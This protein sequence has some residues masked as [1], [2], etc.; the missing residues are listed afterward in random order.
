MVSNTN[1][2][3][4]TRFFC[5]IFN[6]TMAEIW[7]LLRKSGVE[8]G[9]VGQEICPKTKSIHFHVFGRY[10]KKRRLTAIGKHFG[11]HI[12]YIK[13]HP[14]TQEYMY[15]EAQE[16]C[17]KDGLFQE[18][19]IPE[20]E[21]S[22]E[23]KPCPFVTCINLAMAGKFDEIR[24]DFPKMY[25]IHLTKW[26]AIFAE[27][28]SKIQFPNRKCLWIHG[29]SGIGKSRWVQTNFPSAYRKNAGEVHFERY[30]GEKV[31]VIEDFLPDHR[32]E[33]SHQMLMISDI[34]SFMPKVRY[35]SVCL[36][37]ELLIVTSNYSLE[38]CF[39]FEQGRGGISP[40]QR[41]FIVVHAM[42]WAEQENDLLIKVGNSIF[43]VCLTGW[44]LT[45][46]YITFEYPESPYHRPKNNIN[47]LD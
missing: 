25:V 44:L 1:S 39:P 12:E 34:Y 31:V 20:P 43:F 9:V 7:E 3:F 5:T 14:Q 45:H 19:G 4:V 40:F 17:K 24:T 30:A 27:V 10:E 41:R 22:R 11:C 23:V 47:D 15:Y 6:K 18:F 26:K 38:E 21:A 42:A 16:Y 29:L 33:W 32:K 2:A 35:G 28:Q 8:Y 36:R 37:H 13:K 46:H